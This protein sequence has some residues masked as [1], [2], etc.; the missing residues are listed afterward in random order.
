MVSCA[1]VQAL[2]AFGRMNSDLNLLRPDSRAVELGTSLRDH[3]LRHDRKGLRGAIGV[4]QEAISRTQLSQPT[5][6]LERSHQ[7][8]PQQ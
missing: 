1:L 4:R 5:P 6:N 7:G 3:S 8:P 2:G